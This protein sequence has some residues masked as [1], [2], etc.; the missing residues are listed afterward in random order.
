M[1]VCKLQLPLFNLIYLD[2]YGQ[3]FDSLARSIDIC[4][5]KQLSYLRC[6]TAHF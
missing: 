1:H 3:E 6:F 2:H 4:N 5:H